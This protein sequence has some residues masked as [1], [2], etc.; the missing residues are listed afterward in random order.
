VDISANARDL[1]DYS[2]QL[3]PDEAEYVLRQIVTR[4]QRRLQQLLAPHM[5]ALTEIASRK[6]PPPVPL[7]N[8]DFA[9]YTGP[10][11]DEMAGPWRPP[12]WLEA[13]CRDIGEAGDD[14]RWYRK[15]TRDGADPEQD[16][17]TAPE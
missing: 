3:T 6:P 7:P 13:L 4:A 1:E 15:R 11:A 14:L 9:I 17:L 5:D 16:P 10:T 2:M 8:G 12:Q